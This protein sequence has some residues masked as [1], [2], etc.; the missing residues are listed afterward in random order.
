MTAVVVR[1][2]KDDLNLRFALL[3]IGLFF[4]TIAVPLYLTKMYMIA[5]AWAAEG[6]IL[7]VIGLRYRSVGTQVGGCVA[8][9]L[10]F[11]QL[12]E[13]LL[14]CRCAARVLS[15]LQNEFKISRGFAPVDCGGSVWSG[16]ALIDG[17]GN[18]GVV[19]A[20]RTQFSKYSSQSA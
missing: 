7:M 1:R 10:S 18:N 12:L 20:L 9:L 3:A 8:L 14:C 2:C 17:G 19:V 5:M 13:R 4:L 11:G 16:I 6:V 15:G